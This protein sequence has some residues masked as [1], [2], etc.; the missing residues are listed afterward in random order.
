MKKNLAASVRV[1]L[2]ALAKLQ[3]A[4]FNQILLR[5]ALE[6]MLYRMSISAHADQFLLKG[7]L[8][9]AL[10]YDM[11]HRPTRDA[12]LL[13]FGPSDLE[14]IADS[15]RDIASVQVEDGIHFD[16]ASIM[17]GEIRKAAGYAGA[18][19]LIDGELAGAR[20][21]TQIDIGFGDAVTPA[22]IEAAYPVLLDDFPAPQL[23]IYPVYSVVA[24]KLHAIVLLGMTNT[25][26][27]DYFDLSIVLDRETLD[28]HTLASAIAATFKRREMAVPLQLP[29]G[30]SDEFADDFSRQAL[31]Q[32][33]LRKNGLPIV[34]LP[35][36]VLAIR[37]SLMSALGLAISDLTHKS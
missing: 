13:G 18:R 37:H 3:G 10:W 30:L 16:P 1:R 21:K 28:M 5:F 8:L 32:A 15:F 14:S 26:L 22:A 31:W 9:F 33:F 34:P 11:P 35:D 27:K 25:R 17:V 7:A 19:V 29:I 20:C 2:L 23:R 24:E 6:R 4:D 36:V 12:D